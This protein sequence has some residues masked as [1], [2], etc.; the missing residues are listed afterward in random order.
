MAESAPWTF[1]KSN[2]VMLTYSHNHVPGILLWQCFCLRN[3]KQNSDSFFNYDANLTWVMTT[4]LKIIFFLSMLVSLYDVISCD[5]I[6]VK[7]F[8]KIWGTSFKFWSRPYHVPCYFYYASYSTLTSFLFG[9]LFHFYCWV[10][11]PYLQH[12]QLI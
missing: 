11:A 4:E 9:F 2:T 1:C 5:I 7:N 3:A 6:N 8:R 10:R 12:F